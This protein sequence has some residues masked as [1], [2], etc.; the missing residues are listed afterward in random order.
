MTAPVRLPLERLDIATARLRMHVRARGTGETVL[1]VHGNASSSAFWDETLEHLPGGWRGLAPD[2]RGYGDTEDLLIDATRGVMD[3]VDD[4]LALLST[5]EVRS[6]HIVGHSLG[7][8]VCWGLVAA[9]AARI[10]SVTLVAPGSPYGFGGTRDAQ[11]TPCW[12]DFAGSGGGTVNPEFARRIAA[13]ER[14]EVDAN[15][16]RSVMNTYYFKPPFR[17]E[18]EEDLLSSLLS[19]RVGPERYPGDFVASD[20][21]PGVAPGVHGPINALSPKYAAAVAQAALNTQPK[22]PVLWVRGD[23]DTIVSDNSLFDFGTLGQLG[24][25]P[26]W[27][28]A[29][30]YPPQPMVTQTRSFLEEYAARGGEWREVVMEGVGH[31]PFVERPRE[32]QALLH[33]HLETTRTKENA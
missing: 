24:A 13:G 23:S 3:W 10:R 27:P 31:T 29:E 15:S 9:D 7:G 22:P 28:G 33:Q 20:N 30:L 32:F 1:F 2:L 4:L 11:G 12:P 16:P 19:E 17:P 14:D 25:I 18:R 8:A 6:Y 21:W 5:L 26:G